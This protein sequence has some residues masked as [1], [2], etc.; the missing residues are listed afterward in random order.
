[1]DC[2]SLTGYRCYS[3]CGLRGK[4]NCLLLVI[5]STIKETQR[6]EEDQ[7]SDD[8]DYYDFDDGVIKNDMEEGYI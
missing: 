1:M 8:T 3:R 2:M 5:D 6:G 7:S 4:K